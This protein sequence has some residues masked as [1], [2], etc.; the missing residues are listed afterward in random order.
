MGGTLLQKVYVIRHCEAEGQPPE[1]QLTEKGLL[2]A[3]ELVDFF[4]TITINRIISSPYKR[5][6]D[7]IQPFATKFNLDVET[8][9]RLEERVL[10]KEN[11]SDWLE[12]LSTTFDNLDL[13]FEGGESSRE[14]MNRIV[15]VINE[16]FSNNVQNTIIVSHGNLISLLLKYFNDDFGFDNWRSLS[17]ADIYLLSNE[18]NIVTFERLWNSN[19]RSHN[20]SSSNY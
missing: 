10:S 20:D 9:K 4:S 13:K 11:L 1:A 18:G 14:A 6:I 15:E 7:T 16:V 12:K 19:G 8:D 3:T 5:A 2:Q 17:N